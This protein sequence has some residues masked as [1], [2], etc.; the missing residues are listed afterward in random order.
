MAKKN[1]DSKLFAFLAVLLT[2][3]G[4]IIAY[5]AKKEDKYVM[6]YAKQGL[7]LFFA[8]LVAW[9]AGMSLFFVTFVGMILNLIVLVLW[10]IGMVYSLSGE[11]K[12][13]PLIGQ[14]AKSFNF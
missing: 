1:D 6:F 3:I 9:I 12:E 4:F 7:V 13:V 10:I 8:W 14:F 5:A 2:L 11:M